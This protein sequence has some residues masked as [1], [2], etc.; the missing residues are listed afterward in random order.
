M[1]HPWEGIAQSSGYAKWE[2][3]GDS[4]KGKVTEVGIGQDMNGNDCPQVI[5]DTGDGD[6]ITV[7]ASQAQ[8]RSKLIEARP[9]V[10]D[11]I[12]IV[13]TGVEKRAGGKTLKQFD[14]AVKPGDPSDSADPV[15]APSSGGRPSAAD[16]I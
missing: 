11:T 14:V 1:T 5:V 9:N 8:L 7:S 10:G 3:E 16:L 4:V 15:G 13:F 2:N 6:G 12:A